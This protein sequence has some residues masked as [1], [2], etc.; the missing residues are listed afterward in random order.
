MSAPGGRSDEAS[1]RRCARAVGTRGRIP[2]RFGQ[3]AV[4]VFRLFFVKLIALLGMSAYFVSVEL[5]GND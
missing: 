3:F 1:E 2:E 4:A 5:S